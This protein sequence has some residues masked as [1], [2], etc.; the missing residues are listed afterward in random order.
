MAL[1]KVY[2]L[3]VGNQRSF[4]NYTYLLVDQR[5]NE[6]VI[7]DPGWEFDTITASLFAAGAVLKGVLLT[8]HH[9]D[10]TQLASDFARVFNVPVWISEIERDHYSFT[11]RNLRTVRPDGLF[12]VGNFEIF[13]HH[14]PGHTKGSLCFQLGN[15]LFT[16]DTLFIEGCGI[17]LSEGGALEMFNSLQKLKAS[18]N[19]SVL[20][21]PGHSYGI[22]PGVTFTYLL[23]QNI[24]FHFK[25]GS[26]F[27]AFRLRKNQKGL[28]NF[29]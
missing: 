2:P 21:Y 23:T 12:S 25:K 15:C 16:G 10:H 11:C 5:T 1:L 13:P 4:I 17:C 14:T 9:A 19:P 28:F 29:K 20:I 26:D 6:A 8:H 24:Y 3:R 7:I 18:I 27:V 22:T